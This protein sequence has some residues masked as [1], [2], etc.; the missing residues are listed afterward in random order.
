MGR[1]CLMEES[2]SDPGAVDPWSEV[3]KNKRI[4][5]SYLNEM[6]HGPS[7][8]TPT[9]IIED[10]KP[11]GL[12]TAVWTKNWYAQLFWQLL[13]VGVAALFEVS[14][15]NGLSNRQ[16]PIGVGV[17]VLAVGLLAAFIGVGSM[18]LPRRRAERF[19]DGTFVF[20]RGSKRL[21]V[22]PGELDALGYVYGGRILG[23]PYPL[24]ITSRRGNCTLAVLSNMR[25]LVNE[26]HQQNPKATL[27]DPFDWNT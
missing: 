5:Q 24:S 23:R 16:V 6:Q 22:R 10:W 8:P 21:V 12:P 20:S 25:G 17:L 7:E 18:L 1:K 19:D 13:Y 3:D 14:A 11:H 26:L 2:A 9:E 27:I 4:A 15:I